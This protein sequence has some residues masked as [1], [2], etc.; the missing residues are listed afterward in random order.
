VPAGCGPALPAGPLSPALHPAS[1][2]AA[3]TAP[4]SV[5]VKNFALTSF[6]GVPAFTR[7]S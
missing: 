7:S 6:R 2:A 4:D 1:T 5:L 3:K